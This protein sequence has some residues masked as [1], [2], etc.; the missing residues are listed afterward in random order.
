MRSTRAWLWM[1]LSLGT[2]GCLPSTAPSPGASDQL[3]QASR[4]SAVSGSRPEVWSRYQE[5]LSWQVMRPAYRTEHGV[6]KAS[7]VLRAS[8]EAVEAYRSLQLG[9]VMP[10]ESALTLLVTPEDQGERP[11]ILVMHR[12]GPGTWKFLTLRA[13]GTLDQADDSGFCARCHGQARA[14]ALFG[15]P[16]T[17]DG[18]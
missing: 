8:P 16:T 14:D 7:A 1:V 10:H 6:R 12:D 3:A 11:Y 2:E 15:L 13:D 9:T 4:A 17:E 18:R 5:S